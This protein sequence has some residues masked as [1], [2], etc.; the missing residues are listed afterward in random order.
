VQ[1]VGDSVTNP[2]LDPLTAS[3]LRVQARGRWVERA[4]LHDR[5]QGAREVRLVLVSAPPGFGKT[6]LLADWLASAQLPCAWLT[7]DAGDNDIVRFARYAAAAAALLGGDAEDPLQFEPGRQFDPEPVLTAILA[8]LETAPG[9]AGDGVLVLDDYHL[10]TESAIHRLVASLLE[11]LPPGV[12]L[13]IATRADPPLPLARLRA[14][15]ELLELRAADLKFNTQEAAELLRSTAGELDQGGGADLTRR[16]EGW[17]AA[18]RLA[19][20]SLQGR[21]N[22]AELVRRFG[23]THRYVLDYVVDEVLAGLPHE[24]HDFLLRTSILER[25][26]GALCDAV[27]GGSDGQARLEELERS[28]LLI[29]PLDEERRWYRYHALFAEILR[30]RLSATHPAEVGAL[31]ARASA[32]HEERANDE[33]AVAHALAS[34]D[35]ERICRV[36]VFACRQR[37]RAGEMSTVRRWLDALPPDA[38]RGDAELIVVEAWYRLYVAE[39]EG[40]ARLLADAEAV[41]ADG[42]DG[43]PLRRAA[44]SAELA[45]ARSYLASMSADGGTAAIEQARRAMALLPDGLPAASEANLRGSAHALLALGLLRAGE[46]DAA[47]E[48]YE[49]SLADLRASG[50]AFAV[51]RSITDIA[52]I[53]IDRGDPERAVRVCETE[54]QRSDDGCSVA[55]SGAIWAALARARAEIGQLDLAEAAARR[56]L[57]LATRAGDATSLRYAQ[58][59]LDRIAPLLARAGTAGTAIRHGAAGLVEPLTNRELEVLQ[60]VATGRSNTEIAAGLFVTVGTVKAHVHSICGKLGA[61]NRVQAIVRARELGLLQ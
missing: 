61:G 47:V 11:R 56:A 12:R 33:E 10:I 21:T 32:W 6:T 17:A 29:V 49:A 25:L 54:L 4:R 50:N 19:A 16:T 45:L 3:K 59:T 28:N 38:A 55:R 23:A 22:H 30:A 43:P 7:L 24:T 37:L 13:A 60:L 35:V 44:I 27:A 51:G 1:E 58:A 42:Q 34:R 9:A 46:L 18:L 15:G 14:R 39:T 26:C 40:V 52:R 53:A 8:Q 2:G 48:A 41:L 36:M 5:L 57:E 20:V 31:H